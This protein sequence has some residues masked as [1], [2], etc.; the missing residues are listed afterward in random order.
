MLQYN[1]CGNAARKINATMKCCALVL[2]IGSALCRVA[3]NFPAELQR[4]PQLNLIS[5]RV[6]YIPL[7]IEFM[8][9]LSDPERESICSGPGATKICSL[10]FSQPETNQESGCFL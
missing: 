10:S 9:L 4:I 6:L 8:V 3:T 5:P 2:E 1:H 7:Q